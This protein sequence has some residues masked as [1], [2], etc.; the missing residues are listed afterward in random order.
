MFYSNTLEF[1]CP[2][3]NMAYVMK[4]QM[5]AILVIAYFSAV[6]GFRHRWDWDAELE[7][8]RLEDWTYF[9]IGSQMMP[10]TC[11]KFFSLVYKNQI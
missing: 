1:L 9:K 6:Y 10:G 5:I 8:Q 2:W 7:R 11:L 3:K 4:I